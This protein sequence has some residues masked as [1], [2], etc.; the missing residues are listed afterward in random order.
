M[1]AIPL[2][3]RLAL[4]AALACPLLVALILIPFRGNVSSTNLSLVLVMVIVAV[5]ALGNRPAGALAALSAAAWYDFFLTRPYEGFDITRGGDLATTILILAVGLVVSQLTE[6]LQLRGCRFEYGTLLGHPA[7]LEQDGTL[8]V[9]RRR[10]DVDQHGWPQ[11]GDR[12]TRQRRR[13]LPGPVHAHTR[14]RRPLHP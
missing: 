3:D 11:G 10:W 7:R 12:T 6:L 2:R 8:T 1:I 5:A 4:A 9:G 14:A 13:A